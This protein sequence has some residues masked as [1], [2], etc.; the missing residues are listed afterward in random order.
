MCFCVLHNL[1]KEGL[2][3]KWVLP[4]EIKKSS[5]IWSPGSRTISHRVVY[6]PILIGILLYSYYCYMLKFC[7]TNQRALRDLGYLVYIETP[8]NENLLLKPVIWE[9]PF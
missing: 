8:L 2:E 3:T 7:F 6:V 1:L 5:A 4:A 9:Q